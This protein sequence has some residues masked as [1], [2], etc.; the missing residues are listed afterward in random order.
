[1]ATVPYKLGK[2]PARYLASDRLFTSFRNASTPVTVPAVFGHGNT[3]ADWG[4]NGNDQW[5]D[6]VFAGGAH[7]TE[8]INNLS[9]GGVTGQEVIKVTT[10]NSLS[11]YSAV[12]G[13][14]FTE[15]TD[16]GTDVH[17]AL[18]YRLKTGLVDS[19]GKRHKIAAYVALEVGNM[20]HLHEAIFLFSAVG[21]GFEVPSYAQEQF[22][23]NQVWSVQAKNAQIEGGHYVPL[24]GVPAVGNLA[25]ITW[26]RRQ[27]M[28]DAFYQQYCDEAWAFLTLEDLNAKTQKSW[29]GYGWKELSEDLKIVV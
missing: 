17:N 22:S 8:L 16:R 12:T 23:A 13:F 5:G 20:Q 14:K 21:I 3:F 4:M 7:E 15:A 2:L 24:V 25:A 29:G 19:T 10:E 18:D 1:M 26:G 9:H 6:C 28:T 27:V 11:D